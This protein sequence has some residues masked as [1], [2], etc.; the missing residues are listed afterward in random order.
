MK[1]ILIIILILII[2]Y[3]D[4]NEYK[5]D[6]NIYYGSCTQSKHPMIKQIIE[7]YNFIYS[8]D[9]DKINVYIQDM[10]SKKEIPSNINKNAFVGKINNSYIIGSKKILWITLKQNLGLEKLKTIMPM[11]Y[12]LNNDIEILKKNYKENKLYILKNEQQRQEGLKITNDWLEIINA[13][14][15]GYVLVQEIITNPL[16]F[17]EHKLNFRVYLLI[18]CNNKQKQFYMHKGGMVGYSKKGW[19]DNTLDD[20]D[21]QISSAHTSH[22]VYDGGNP[23]ILS[24]LQMYYNNEDWTK[25]ENG[26]NYIMTELSKGISGNIKNKYNKEFQLYGVDIMF[27][28]KL[29]PY[30]LECNAGAGMKT[31]NE[32]TDGKMRLKLYE[33]MFALL[34]LYTVHNNGYMLLYETN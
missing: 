19:N 32:D 14:K 31:W 9:Y 5:P 28:N 33:D 22:N 8:T 13:Y 15:N 29:N 18:I 34:G 7:K 3:L 4:N 24:E 26:I 25:I 2:F 20:F 27:D 21:V 12:I 23:I 30:L 11:T 17:R 1:I 6:K 10:C 16:L